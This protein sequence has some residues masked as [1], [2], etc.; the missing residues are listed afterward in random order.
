MSPGYS[1]GVDM[2]LLS[3]SGLKR[4]SVRKRLAALDASEADDG[5]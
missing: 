3:L 1:W 5:E 4:A 2:T